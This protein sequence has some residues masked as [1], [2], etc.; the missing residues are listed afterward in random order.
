MI[1]QCSKPN[2]ILTSPLIE[3]WYTTSG[4]TPTGMTGP[5]VPFEGT[6]FAYMESSGPAPTNSTFSIQ[7]PVVSIP[8]RGST[9]LSLSFLMFGGDIGSFNIEVL[10]GTNIDVVFTRNGQQHTDGTFSSWEQTS[11]DLSSYAGTDVSIQF[12]AMKLNTG[13]G[14][15]AIDDISICHTPEPIPTLGSWALIGLALAM[16]ILGLVSLKSRPIRAID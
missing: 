5:D 11:L 12:R 15:I 14:D 16:M 6:H 13:L 2:N 7:T 10:Q 4:P 3:G 1:H 8:T 9:N